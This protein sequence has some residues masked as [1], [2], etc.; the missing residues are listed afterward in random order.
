MN[1][2]FKSWFGRVLPAARCL[3]SGGVLLLAVGLCGQQTADAAGASAAGV[4]PREPITLALIEGLSGPFANAGEAVARNLTWAVERVNARG[5]VRLPGGNRL[6]ELAQLDSKG[7]IDEAL[8]QL[9]LAIDRG[10]AFVTQGNSSAVAG[11]LVEALNK[12]N[13]RE[14]ARRA[15]LL[16]YSAVEPSLTNEL[17]SP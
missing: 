5:G 14:A 2:F 7:Q 12:H 3:A 10:S 4:T 15:L 17:C 9:R 8:G 11:A 16:N 13:T 1:K 6:L